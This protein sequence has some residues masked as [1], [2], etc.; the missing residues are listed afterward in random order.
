M[1]IQSIDS[2][3]EINTR[4]QLILAISEQAGMDVEAAVPQFLYT[5][6]AVDSALSTTSTNP[7][8]NKIITERINTVQTAI[9]TA[10]EDIDNLAAS[11]TAMTDDEVTAMFN[12]VF[13]D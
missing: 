7:V 6:P 11:F 3:I 8:Q 2:S 1:Q 5:V 9:T 10:Q 13:S 12:R 4:E